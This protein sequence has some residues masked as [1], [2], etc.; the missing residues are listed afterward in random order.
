MSINNDFYKVV[1]SLAGQGTKGT[2]AIVDYASFMDYGKL[3]TNLSVSTD[4]Q[5]IYM[6]N[7]L[8]KI[9]MVLQDNPEY[10]GQYADIVVSGGDPGEIIETIMTTFYEATSNAALT[11]LEDGQIYTD[12][13][14]VNKVKGKTLYHMNT[15]GKEIAITLED[16]RWKAAFK[17]PEALD[18]FNRGQMSAIVNSL[19]L[20]AETERMA[21]VADVINTCL[22]QTANGTDET[23]GAQ[24]YDLLAIYNSTHG[25]SLTAANALDNDSFVRWSVSVIRDVSLLMTK[26]SNKFNIH[27][28]D[29]DDNW[30]TF[31]PKEYQ[32]LKVNSLFKR[33]IAVSK[34][35]SYHVEEAGLP[36]VSTEVVP[37]WQNIDL[38]MQVES[39][40]A[41]AMDTEPTYGPKVLAVLFDKRRIMQQIQMDDTETARNP[42]RRYTNYFWQ[43]AFMAYANEYANAVVFTLEGGTYT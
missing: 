37:Y 41:S 1:N 30:L 25:T 3:A 42:R 8:N 18:R 19:N 28:A 38:R 29:Q 5:N 26:V 15:N 14:E 36:D 21:M 20:L 23:V 35:D 13:F 9:K 10:I 17:N 33:A 32:R 2:P 22:K 39:G 12:Q 40:P 43:T 6:T 34:M 24:N 31:T 16:V 7:F 4:L 11:E 27:G